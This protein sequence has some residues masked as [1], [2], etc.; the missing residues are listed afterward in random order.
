MEI[1]VTQD[2]I[3]RGARGSCTSDPVALSLLNAGFIR[4]YVGVNEIRVNGRDGVYYDD[5]AE[6]P[7][8]VLNFLRA[9]DNGDY[10]Q[11]FTFEVDL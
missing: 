3:D 4:P 2:H 1:T 9:H 8:A 5:F 10:A 7:E 11:P 6:T